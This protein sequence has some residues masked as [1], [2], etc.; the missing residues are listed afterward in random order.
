MFSATDVASFLACQHIA[1]LDRT[2]ERKEVTKP[3][4]KYHAVD[5]L[6][7]LGLEH[8]QSYFRQLAETIEQGKC[9]SSHRNK[10]S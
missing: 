4:F 6:R 5:L 9:E 8:E 10:F 7:K 1:T 2:E 3:F